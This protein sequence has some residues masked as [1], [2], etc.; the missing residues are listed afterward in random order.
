MSADRVGVE[1][2]G[3]DA[4]WPAYLNWCG[5]MG[6]GN[7]DLANIE[8]R[9]NANDLVIASPT[10]CTEILIASCSG[11][12]RWRNCPEAGLEYPA[13][14]RI[15]WPGTCGRLT[16][17]I[18]NRI[19]VALLCV[20]GTRSLVAEWHVGAQREARPQALGAEDD[21]QCRAR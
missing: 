13:L 11:W 16:V 14:A 6:M 9:G 5:E 12:D 17:R 15:P 21:L 8:V 10:R 3:V 18:M 19:V 7:Y 1:C 2:M 4:S 20:L